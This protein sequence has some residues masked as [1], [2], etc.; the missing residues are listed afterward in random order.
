VKYLKGEYHHAIDAKS[1]VTIP[2][3]LREFMSVEHEGYTLV[4]KELV[5]V[6]SYDGVL[7]LYSKAAYAENSPKLPPEMDVDE[8]V[9][10]YKRIWFG[11][12]QDVEIDRLG[13][14]LIPEP[15][16]K[17]CGLARDVV[18]VGVENRIE[19]WPQDRW[20]SHIGEQVKQVNDLAAHT[21]R[22]AHGQPHPAKTAGAPGGAAESGAPEA[23]KSS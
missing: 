5:A 18:I 12:A 15:M 20:E 19:V 17:R 1:R 7:H 4:A 16:A 14:V 21:M 13:R 10:N 9:R 23:P 6:P 2:A 22:L 11:L 3:K 8:K